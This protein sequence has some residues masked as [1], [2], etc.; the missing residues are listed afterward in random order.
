MASENQGI[1]RLLNA[2]D[3]AAQLVKAAR[4]ART[5]RLAEAEMEAKQ[6]IQAFREELEKEFLGDIDQKDA[7][8]A[9]SK[10]LETA[11][12]TEIS[13]MKTG[14]ESNKDVVV[15]LLMHHIT[16]VN[17]E[18]DPATKQSLLSFVGL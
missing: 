13:K 1:N 14:Y 18:L 16:S 5:K 11:R 8:T 9:F 12:N 10:E 3:E 17:V 4:Q 6:E 7:V 15:Q 2:E